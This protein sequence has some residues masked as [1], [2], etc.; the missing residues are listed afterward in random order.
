MSPWATV[1][2]TNTPWRA[3]TGR[4][5][6]KSAS[7][8]SSFGSSRRSMACPSRVVVVVP[9]SVVVVPATAPYCTG[10]VDAAAREAVTAAVRSVLVEVARRRATVTYEE[11]LGRLAPSERAVFESDLAAVLRSISTE[12]ERAGR[13]LL[14]AVVVRAGGLPGGGFFRLA[15][16]CGREVSDR[17]SAWEAE[18]ERVYS[19]YGP[20]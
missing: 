8:V 17:R 15:E 6:T 14:T 19:A 18:V 13:G 2:R 1:E 12:E 3:S 5:A 16:E 10:L 20:G 4:S 9:V 11:L 7:P